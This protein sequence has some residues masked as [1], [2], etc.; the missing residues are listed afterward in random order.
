MSGFLQGRVH[1]TA[2]QPGGRDPAGGWIGEVKA[3]QVEV[4]L[5]DPKVDVDVAALAGIAVAV[6]V[7]VGLSRV[8]H[9][10]TDVTQIGDS[11]RV[12]VSA[13]RSGERRSGR[14]VVERIRLQQVAA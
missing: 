7:A 12:G 13:T 8:R 3:Q 11:I 2:F 10:G 9:V 14:E 4:V 1:L 5:V 6:E